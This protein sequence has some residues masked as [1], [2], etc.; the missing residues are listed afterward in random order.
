MLNAYSEPL[1]FEL[2]PVPAGYQGQW[3]RWIDTSHES[4]EDICEWRCSLPVTTTHYNVQARSLAILLVKETHSG[5]TTKDL[6][7]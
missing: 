7:T 4:P 2:P 3:R 6:A 1:V 5:V